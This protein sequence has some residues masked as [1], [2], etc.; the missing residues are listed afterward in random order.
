[1]TL[2]RPS[3]DDLVEIGERTHIHL[4]DDELDVLPAIVDAVIAG[5]DELDQYPDPLRQ[6][7]PAVRIPGA[8]PSP[9]EDPLNGVVR[10]CSVRAAPEAAGPLSGKTIGVKDT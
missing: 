1:M 4:N 2:R 9:E 8:R 10:S 5:Y 3:I 6:V 7:T